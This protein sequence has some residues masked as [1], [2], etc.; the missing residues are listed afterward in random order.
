MKEKL[1]TKKVLVTKEV[2]VTKKAKITKDKELAVL[3]FNFVKNSC[4]NQR[5]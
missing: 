5:I 4:A 2:L 3:A 1:I